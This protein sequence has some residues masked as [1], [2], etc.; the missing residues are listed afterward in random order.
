M[1]LDHVQNLHIHAVRA[2]SLLNDRSHSSLRAG[3][4]IGPQRS[5]QNTSL[6][7]A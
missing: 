5:D 7:T 2:R 3:V 6:S 4:L 1:I